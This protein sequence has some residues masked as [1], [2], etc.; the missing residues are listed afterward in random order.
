MNS[1]IE[2]LTK[3]ISASPPPDDKTLGVFYRAFVTGGA[4][5][6]IL[7]GWSPR[8]QWE[9][10]SWA[11]KVGLIREDK[12]TGARCSDEQYT[13]VTYRPTEEAVAYLKEKHNE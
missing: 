10:V 13:A 11:Q 8:A 6:I 4:D 2:S 9:D 12:D 1:T 3:A 5:F 7:D